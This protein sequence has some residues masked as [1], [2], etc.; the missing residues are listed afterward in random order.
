MMHPLALA[1]PARV[2]ERR[3]RLDLTVRSR[4]TAA[5]VDVRVVRRE[6][7]GVFS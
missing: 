6:S 1:D 4:A 2:A 3:I 7:N 5:A